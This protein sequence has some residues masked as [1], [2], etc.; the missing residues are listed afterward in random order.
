MKKIVIR[1]A[2]VVLLLSFLPSQVV[3]ACSGFII[4]KGL[5]TDGSVMFGRTEDYPLSAR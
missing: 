2:V 1:L 3:Q 5:T 4:G